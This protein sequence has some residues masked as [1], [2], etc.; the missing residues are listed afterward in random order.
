MQTVRCRKRAGRTFRFALA[1]Y[2][3]APLFVWACAGPEGVEERPKLRVGTTGT[4]PP[5]SQRVDARFVGIDVDLA[6]NLGE[7][8][9]QPVELVPTSWSSL[10]S[11]MVVGGYDLAMSG[12][13]I[14]PER[15][16]AGR[17]S[18]P[19]LSVGQ[20][21]LVRCRDVGRFAALDDANRLGV[22]VV[23]V[24][25]GANQEFVYQRLPNAT[26]VHIDAEPRET[27]RMVAVGEAHVTFGTTL[28]VE[29]FAGR[30]PRL[31]VGFGGTTI[32]TDLPIGVF[33]AQTFPRH[34]AIDRWVRERTQDGSIAAV[35]RAHLEVR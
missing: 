13:Y 23:V 34:V 3:I 24:R 32:S 4:N 21:G 8:L 17:F 35:V 12:I 25:G 30:D 22:K 2:A 1:C 33:M 9:G 6:H 18:E 16:Q 14:T 26:I 31:C 5:Y 27:A 15:E 19:Y 10:V 29:Y 20:Q 7:W 11:D 28:G